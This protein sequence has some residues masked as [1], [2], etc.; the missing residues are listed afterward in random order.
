MATSS[1]THNFVISGPERVQRFIDA[2]DAADKDRAPRKPA[3]IRELKDPKDLS[4]FMAR[5]EKKHKDE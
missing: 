2:L 1:I 5:W 3:A 4:E